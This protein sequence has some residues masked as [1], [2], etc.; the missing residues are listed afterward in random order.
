MLVGGSGGVTERNMAI[1][2]SEQIARN[3]QELREMTRDLDPLKV[4][5]DLWRAPFDC[6]AQPRRTALRAKTRTATANATAMTPPS[7]QGKVFRRDSGYRAVRIAQS[8]QLL[9]TGGCRICTVG[10]DNPYYTYY[11]F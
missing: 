4:D 10:V 11:T 8:N 3:G 2:V 5:V 6:A 7:R 1:D 9:V